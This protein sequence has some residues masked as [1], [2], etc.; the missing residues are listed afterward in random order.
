MEE[1]TLCE[2]LAV[3]ET[4]LKGAAANARQISAVPLCTLLLVTRIHVRPAPETLLTVV[5]GVDTESVEINASS[6][7]LPET[8]EK[9]GLVIVEAGVP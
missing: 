9:G 1:A 3:T 5:L 2:S 6:S 4:L 8:V 7:T